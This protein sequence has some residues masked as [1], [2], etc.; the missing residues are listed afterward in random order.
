MT[1]ISN[2]ETIII[3]CLNKRSDEMMG[4]NVKKIQQ[5]DISEVQ[6]NG[7]K[8]KMRGMMGKRISGLYTL[9][10]FHMKSFGVPCGQQGF[11]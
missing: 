6:I 9:K 7:M 10:G 5:R 1:K 11:C 8:K 4:K 2:E 3:F